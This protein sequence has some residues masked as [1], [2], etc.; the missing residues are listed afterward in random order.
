LFVVSAVES[1][2][3]RVLRILNKGHTRDDVELVLWELNRVGIALR[4]TFVAF[5]PWT[6]I[7]D[8]IELL[9][10]V[11]DEDLIDHVDPVQF[12]IRLL[13]PPGSL[14][15]NDPEV[16]T[17]V[18]E[19][20]QRQ[21]TYRWSHPY[22]RMDKLQSEVPQIVET[23]AAKGEDASVTFDRVLELAYVVSGRPRPQ[24]SANSRSDLNASARSKRTTA[25]AISEI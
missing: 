16:A 12:S 19:L 9:E 17:I 7:D 18:E 22:V 4:P 13:I 3:D 20:D 21:F 25:S 8:Y 2:G 10:W 14:L 6:S 15:L 11:W 23:A 24:P 1:L 5:T